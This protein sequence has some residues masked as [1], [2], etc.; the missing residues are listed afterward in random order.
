MREVFISHSARGD[1]FATAVLARI[2][3]RLTTKNFQ[4]RVDQDDIPPGDEWRPHIVEWLARCDAAVVLL[5]DKALGSHWVRREVNILMWRRALD[6]SVFVVP[7]LLG[8][9]TTGAVKM[10]GLEELR[11]VQFARTAKGEVQDAE[12]L[13]ELVLDRFADLPDAAVGENP[14]SGWLDRLDTYLSQ[15]RPKDALARAA[16]ALG[17][18]QAYLPKVTAQQGGCLFL[19]HQ[20]LVASPKRMEKAVYGLGPALQAGTLSRLIRELACVWVDAEAARGV[21]PE[22]GCVPREMTV[23]LNAGKKGTA[24]LY[25]QRANCGDPGRYQTEVVGDL[26]TGEDRTGERVRDWERTVRREFFGFAEDDHDLPED[27]FDRLHYLVIDK[28]GPPDTEFVEAVERL[29][30]TFSWLIVMVTTGTGIQ[31]QDIQ[32]AFKNP[33]VPKPLLTASLEA[34]ELARKTRLDGLPGQLAGFNQEYT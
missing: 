17:L 22:P 4:P 28:L 2:Q 7:V 30:G 12:A 5:N 8:D 13:A 25:I 21:L 18:P 32:A 14:M 27:L 20:F 16:T 10:A 15:A 33:V 31:E 3:D 6:A 34:T 23:L 29:H 9:L 1:A 19:A 24:E 26:P 11:P